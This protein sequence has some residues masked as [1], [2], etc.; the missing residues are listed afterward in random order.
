MSESSIN[1]F[2]LKELKINGEELL[3]E[4]NSQDQTDTYTFRVK[5]SARYTIS[6]SGETDTFLSLFGP[7]DETILIAAD[8][9]SGPGLS[10]LLIDDLE[11]GQ[12]FVKVQHLSPLATGSY[13]I[14]VQSNKNFKPVEIQVN[15]AEVIGYIEQSKESDLYTFD[16]AKKGEYIIETSGSSDTFI[17]LFGPNSSNNLIAQDD[18]SGPGVL[19]HMHLSL[20]VGKYFVRV[21]LSSPCCPGTYGIK[22]QSS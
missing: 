19:S 7:D 22:V 21:R 18:D 9:D 11:I 3:G 14:A 4:I 16:V 15:G 10:S 1:S 5:E 17:S 6:T 8:D 12:Y 20:A 2:Q 13:R